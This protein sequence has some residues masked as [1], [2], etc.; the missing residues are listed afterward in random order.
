MPQHTNNPTSS[1]VLS[2]EP[3]MHHTPVDRCSRKRLVGPSRLLLGVMLAA[4]IALALSASSARA[5]A[6]TC[7]NAELRALNNSSGLPDCRAYEMV[8]SPYKQ[9]FAVYKQSYGDDG[10]VAYTSVGSFADNPFGGLYNQYVA[11][12]SPTGWKTIPM[13]PPGQQWVFR[14]AE[15]AQNGMSTDLRSSLWPMR[16]RSEPG[17]RD[18]DHPERDG[19]Y[20]RRP[21]GVFSLLAPNPGTGILRVWAVTPDLSHVV[22]GG[23]WAA[24]A[25]N[26]YEVT[27]GDQ[28]LRPIGVDNSGAPLPGAGVSGPGG[29]CPQGIS[30]D[31]RVI[32]FGTGNESGCYGS[33]ARVGGATTIDLAASQCTR[34]AGDTG[35]VCNADAQVSLVGFA[36]DGS[37]A[38]MTTT[39]QLVNG[40][41]DATNDVYVCEIPAGTIA[42]TGSVNKC[43]NLRQLTTGGAD[44][45]NVVRVSE[46]GSHVYFVAHSVLAA[47]HGANDQTALAG[48]HNLY[49]WQTDAE[50]PEGHTTF[51][52]R[53]V[54]PED[55][56]TTATSSTQLTPDGRYLLINTRDPLVTAGA[57]A[58]TDSAADVYRYDAQTGE[59]LRL[60]TDA[61]GSGGNAEISTL[62][63]FYSAMTDDGH[64]VVFITTEALAPADTN[65]FNDVYA[66]HEGQVS[67]ISPDGGGDPGITASGTDIFFRS[68]SHVT[69]AD[70]DTSVDVFDARVGGGFD[71]R[72]RGSCEGEDCSGA[73]SAPPGLA[74]GAGDLGGQDEVQEPAARFTL[75]SISVAQRRALAQTGRVTVTVIASKPGTV[76]A[77]ATT[78][79]NG[80]QSNGAAA[81]ETMAQAG[82][83]QLTVGLS[84]K[85]RAR[86]VAKRRLSVRIVV[87][88]SRFALAR[89]ATLKLTLAAKAKKVAQGSSVGRGTDDKEGRS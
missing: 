16:P 2:K 41:T 45:E 23:D 42:P 27:G 28:V 55:V 32:F 36:R 87:S 35:G 6:D 44:V 14:L 58:D 73:P 81:Q 82:S 77:R 69:A 79:I 15:G 37:R 18:A 89:S 57:G 48:A 9:G 51:V 3:A 19:I 21:D 63:M 75:R 12:R 39:Q 56:G 53:L 33:R 62:V 29:L 1:T 49:V 61:N 17:E 74:S 26:L 86:L 25:P 68:T 65:S 30:A 4:W 67:L 13:N 54:T 34:G 72:E 38:F 76:S 46:D 40:D 71:L 52:A 64:T 88:H 24:V 11:R 22:L 78:T 83:V 59:W 10:A 60:S 43:P 20:V 84:K 66:W 31:G 70:N 85:A 80:K 50:H 8:T 47:N 5:A 7:P